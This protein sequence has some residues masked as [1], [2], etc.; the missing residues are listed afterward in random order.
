MIP[1]TCGLKTVG[2]PVSLDDEVR[3]VDD[4]DTVV[5]LGEV[6]EMCC[7][8]PY[9]CAAITASLSTTPASFSSDGFFHSG[10]LMRQHSSGAFIVE[11]RKKDVIN[12]GRRKNQREEV[13]N[14][15]LSHPKVKK[16]GLHCRSDPLMGERM[17]ACVI[18]RDGMSLR[19]DET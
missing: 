14:L 6:G 17:C 13:E 1:K 3:L 8:G 12:R 16:Y 7:R 18:L 15:I 9:T 11:G 2:K 5:P 10:D 4:D 19:F